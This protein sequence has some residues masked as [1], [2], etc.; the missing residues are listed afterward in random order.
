MV[1]LTAGVQVSDVVK[2]Q[3]NEATKGLRSS[4]IVTYIIAI[5]K[6]SNFKDLAPV[7]DRPEDLMMVKTFP[8][9]AP[10]VKDALRRVMNGE[11]TESIVFPHVL[12]SPAS[13][14]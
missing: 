12:H 8:D 13:D 9:L 7:V 6:H 10:F 5:G 1:L 11:Y 3:L 4:G 2:Q 14:A